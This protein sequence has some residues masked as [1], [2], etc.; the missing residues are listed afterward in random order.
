MMKK[1]QSSR[2]FKAYCFRQMGVYENDLLPDTF[3]FT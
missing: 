1:D 3:M 2:V